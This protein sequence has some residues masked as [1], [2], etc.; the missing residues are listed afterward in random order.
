MNAQAVPLVA[1]FVEA[2][3]ALR[4][5]RQL[6]FRRFELQIV[7]VEFLI[8]RPCMKQELVRWYCEQRLCKLTNSLQ[9]EV[10]M[11][12]LSENHSRILL[13]DTLH[14]VADILHGNRI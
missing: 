4:V 13:P 7:D 11:V 10:L 12:L 5:P 2:N 1:A 8:H 3:S 14:K 9:I 6:V